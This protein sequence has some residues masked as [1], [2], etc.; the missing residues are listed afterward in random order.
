VSNSEQTDTD[1]DGVGDA[2]DDCPSEPGPATNRGCALP[3][4]GMVEMQVG[5]SASAVDSAAGS[6]APNYI[7]LATLTAAALVALSAGAWDARRRWLR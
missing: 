7:T 6:S 4:G 1:G 3:V 2:C 5:G